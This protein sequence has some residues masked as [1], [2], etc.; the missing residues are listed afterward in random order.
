MNGLTRAQAAVLVNKLATDDAFRALFSENPAAALLAVVAPGVQ[1]AC[2]RT[3][4]L[5]SKAVLQKSLDALT[6]E[7][8]ACCG[9]MK[10]NSLEAAK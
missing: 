3:N 10:P 7:L 2:F 9:S 6:D 8:V 5:A 1:Y 4:T